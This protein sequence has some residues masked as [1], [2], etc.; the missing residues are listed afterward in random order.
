MEK[1]ILSARPLIRVGRVA[2]VVVGSTACATALSFPA[3]PPDTPIPDFYYAAP[4]VI[5]ES[6][7]AGTPILSN[8]VLVWFENTATTPERASI[9]ESI[10][11]VVVGGYPDTNGVGAYAVSI[12]SST[13]DDGQLWKAIDQ[14]NSL[15]AVAI[16]GPVFLP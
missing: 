10:D 16:A 4:N 15:P 6:G 7:R 3:N 1:L 9:V 5:R 2:L 11:G 13:T 14:L 12:P 8:V